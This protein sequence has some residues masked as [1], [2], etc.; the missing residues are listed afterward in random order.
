MWA[1][2]ESKKEKMC[3]P[4]WSVKV[5]IVESVLTHI[6][7]LKIKDFTFTL[8]IW[9]PNKEILCRDI[10]MLLMPWLFK[11]PSQIEN[12][13]PQD[14]QQNKQQPGLR[15]GSWTNKVFP[16]ALASWEPECAQR[17]SWILI[18]IVQKC[19]FWV[20][21]RERSGCHSINCDSVIGV[22]ISCTVQSAFL[23]SVT[24]RNWKY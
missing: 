15:F 1:G 19:T 23:D 17:V 20:V 21:L 14:G 4:A 5:F 9:T 7:Y 16:F 18:F 6:S 11:A 22:V 8:I 12:I 13:I 24:S 3:E 2:S 10:W